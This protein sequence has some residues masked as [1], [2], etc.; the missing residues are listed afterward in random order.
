MTCKKKVYNKI[1]KEGTKRKIINQ[2]A[3]SEKL[4]FSST[5]STSL[6]RHFQSEHKNNQRLLKYE[7]SSA[8]KRALL[9][10]FES[11]VKQLQL[12]RNKG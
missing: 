7:S 11:F 3:K 4:R 6:K 8:L 12:L 1:R 5:K 2:K 10:A 9:L